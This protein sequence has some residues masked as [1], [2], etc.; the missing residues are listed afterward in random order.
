MG[1]KEEWEEIEKSIQDSDRKRLEKYK[2]IDITQK[3]NDINKK[4]NSKN[5]L[6]LDITKIIIKIIIIIIVAWV[7]YKLFT[8]ISIVF[9]NMIN[10]HDVDVENSIETSTNIKAKL[11]SKNV[12][13]KENTGEYFFKIKKLPEIQFKA[14][15][16]FG[17]EKN[18]LSDNLHKYL[19]DKWENEN[20]NKFEIYQNTTEEGLLEYKTYININTFEE[21][22]EGTELIIQ[23]LEYEETWNKNNGKIIDVWQQKENEFVYPLGQLYLTKGENIISPYNQWFQTAD[24]I[25]ENAVKQYKE[26]VK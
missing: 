9:T 23:F 22:K 11:I 15:K 18:D 25:R 17:K 24:S 5:K 1:N 26:L 14:I 20:K 7:G 21:M 8:V 6:L 16:D 2:G 19:F 4:A 10:A 13:E 12:D 3:Y